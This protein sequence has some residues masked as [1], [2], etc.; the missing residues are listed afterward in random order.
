M[1]TKRKAFG[2]INPNAFLFLSLAPWTRTATAYS[3]Q[4]VFLREKC[5][6][7]HFDCSGFV[8]FVDPEHDADF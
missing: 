4:S 3:L 8:L 1:N 7:K 2:V 5:I 6:V